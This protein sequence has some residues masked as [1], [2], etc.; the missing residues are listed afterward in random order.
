MIL[1]GFIHRA[2]GWLTAMLAVSFGVLSLYS[3]SSDSGEQQK[4]QVA[5]AFQIVLP[6]TTT[7]TRA[8][9][10]D[11]SDYDPSDPGN[12]MENRIDVNDIQVVFLNSENNVTLKVTDLCVTQMSGYNNIYNVTATIDAPSIVGTT[13]NDVKVMVF[14]NCENKT[15]IT[16]ATTVSAFANIAFQKSLV[17]PDKWNNYIPMWG[18]STTTSLTFTPGKQVDIGEIWLLRAKAKV[19][20]EFDQTVT[21][22]GYTLTDGSLKLESKVQDDFYCLPSAY[23]TADNTKSMTY[24]DSFHPYTVG[25]TSTNHEF[26]GSTLYTPEYDNTSTGATKAIISFSLEKGGV[27]TNHKLQFKNYD[28]DG[29]PIDGSDY[30]IVRNHWYRFVVYATSSSSGIKIKLNVQPWAKY[31]HDDI[32]M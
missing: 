18:V 30:N 11:W 19:T 17:A 10:T 14:V 29:A 6:Q 3:C 27:T 22:A 8:A 23:S 5:V 26:T 4:P 12:E 31:T 21:D 7:Y 32:V 2:M 24:N 9:N 15:T 1:R 16:D 25:E 13:M 20:V 28:S